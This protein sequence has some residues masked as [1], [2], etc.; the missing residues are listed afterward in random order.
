MYV[1]IEVRTACPTYTQNGYFHLK[2]TEKQWKA[3][4]KL[5]KIL[6]EKSRE[7]VTYKCTEEKN[8][9]HS[10]TAHSSVGQRRRVEARERRLGRR[11]C[12]LTR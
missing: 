4:K 6:L 12:V 2:V 9:A 5:Q 1:R 10:R 7:N 11:C 8:V 3:M